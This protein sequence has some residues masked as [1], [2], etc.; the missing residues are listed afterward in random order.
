MQLD[1]DASSIET[2]ATGKDRSGCDAFIVRVASRGPQQDEGDFSGT[3]QD[4]FAGA[5][6]SALPQQWWHVAAFADRRTFWGAGKLQHQPGGRIKE[7][8]DAKT[9]ARITHLSREETRWR[10][11]PQTTLFY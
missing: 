9:R 10:R 5:G 8:I 2:V 3:V 1:T 4:D 6:D 7:T 11:I